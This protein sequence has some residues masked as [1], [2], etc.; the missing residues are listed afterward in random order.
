VDTTDLRA[1]CADCF[2]LC[3]VALA[4]TRSAG[5]GEDKEAGDPCR[6]LTPAD[7]CGIHARLRESGWSGCTVYDCF[8]A[9]QKVSKV[10]FAGADRRQAGMSA[11]LPV[12]RQ[13]HELLWYL[14]E[15]LA[16]PAAAGLH[17]EA[18]RAAARIEALTLA[19][20]DQLA[21][22]D[23]A[24]ERVPVGDLLRR[25]SATVRASEVPGR[26][27]RH[28]GADLSG[29]R[30]RGARIRGA[31]LR[32]CFLIGADLRGADLRTADL[33]GADLRGADLRGAD[34]T[35]A[36]FVTQTQLNAARGDSATRIPP[37]LSR[38]P[39]WTA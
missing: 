21:A 15:T 17:D 19:A 28:G 18:A 22:I 38:P 6:H 33:L 5:F 31:D 25:V 34:L 11:A 12:M 7:D 16:L 36:L 14:A 26:R 24:A 30:L 27:R 10:T 37:A 4:F 3:C 32:G 1:D 13:L 29:A 20:P 35:G 8:G 9:G 39:H 2:G 23:T